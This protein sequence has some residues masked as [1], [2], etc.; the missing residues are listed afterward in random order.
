[1]HRILTG[2]VLGI[3][4]VAADGARAACPSEF[5]ALRRQLEALNHRANEINNGAGNYHNSLYRTNRR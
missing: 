2:L 3:C 5:A 4:L 1:M